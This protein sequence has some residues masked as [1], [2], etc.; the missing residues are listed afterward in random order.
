MNTT[1]Q[2]VTQITVE[3]AYERLIMKGETLNLQLIKE[4]VEPVNDTTRRFACLIDIVRTYNSQPAM[5]ITDITPL[6][7]GFK[8]WFDS[9]P[10]G[11]W[12]ESQY[13][14]QLVS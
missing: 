5:T 6:M 14:I 12:V 3:E 7:G 1:N 8:L 9:D 2:E 10:V 11:Y 4:F 13:K